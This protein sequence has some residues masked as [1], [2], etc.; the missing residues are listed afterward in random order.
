MKLRELMEGIQLRKENAD[1]DLE[2]SGVCYDSRKVTPGC[3]FVAISGYAVDGNRFIP[4]ALEKG[5]AVVV[6]DRAPDGRVPYL[7]VDSSRA[8]LAAMGV[9]WYGHPAEKMTMVGVTGTNGK[10]SVT[11]LLLSLIHISEPTR[12]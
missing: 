12:P 11:M 7:L 6:T 8:A 10:T 1:L 3:V 4:M 2:I 5:A 9:N